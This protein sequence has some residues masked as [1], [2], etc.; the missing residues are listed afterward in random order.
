MG[1]LQ[2][3]KEKL[4]NMDLPIFTASAQ[5]LGGHKDITKQCDI[6]VV[7]YKDR[8]ELQQGFKKAIIKVDGIL[9]AEV[10]N[11]EQIEKDVTLTRLLLVGIFAFGLK[12]KRKIESNFAIITFQ[13]GLECT[14]ILKL[15]KAD[16]ANKLIS[17]VIKLKS[18]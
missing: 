6:N 18:S 5:Y 14:V 10:K 3:M 9:R 2:N 16:Q 17:N 1:F 11:E 13:D 4:D 15:D 7:G 8:V 12:K